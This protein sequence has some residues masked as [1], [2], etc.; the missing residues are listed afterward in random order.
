[1][2]SVVQVLNSES[3][4]VTRE[5]SGL[6][7]LPDAQD[8][9]SGTYNRDLGPV[10]GRFILNGK[11]ASRIIAWAYLIIWVSLI[12]ILPSS[13]GASATYLSLPSRFQLRNC[14]ALGVIKQVYGLTSGFD[15]YHERAKSNKK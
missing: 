2:A 4:L 10:D 13:S 1:M 3:L 14:L 11:E 5:C 8:A 9:A 12:S 15:S 7:C 6:Q